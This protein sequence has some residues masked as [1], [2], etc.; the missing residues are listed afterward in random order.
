MLAE[1]TA[2]LRDAGVS[3]ESLIQRGQSSDGGVFVVM[4]TH[5]STQAQ[6]QA[7]LDRMAASAN[8]VGTPMMMHIL[9]F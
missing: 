6:V 3:I 9:D 1:L 5:V 2:A 8:V 7:A 4:V